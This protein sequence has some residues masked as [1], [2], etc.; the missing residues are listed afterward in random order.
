MM[1]ENKKF[2]SRVMMQRTSTFDTRNVN[3]ENRSFKAVLSSETKVNRFF[4]TELLHHRKDA[5]DLSKAKHGIPLLFNHDPTK[6]IGRVDKIKLDDSG[7]LRGELSFSNNSLANEVYRDVSEDFL[8]GVSIGYR[9]TEHIDTETGIE[10]T[11]WSLHEVSITAIEADI[12]A[13]VNR[14]IDNNHENTNEGLPMPD[15]EKKQVA[16]AAIEAYKA[17]QKTRKDDI[18]HC[19]TEIPGEWGDLQT[20]AIADENFTPDMVRHEMLKIMGKNTESAGG[21]TKYGEDESDKMQRGIE[22][23]LRV[24]V[25]SEK[26]KAIINGIRS[27]E[28]FGFSMMDIARVC[29]ERSGA[30]IRGRSNLQIMGDAFVMSQRAIHGVVDFPNI[31]ANVS[32]ASMQMAY[33]EAAETWRQWCRVGNLSDFKLTDRP[34]LSAFDDL[35]MVPDKDDYTEGSFS[36]LKESIQLAT[37]GRLFKLTRQAMINDSLDG[38]GRIPQSMGRAAARTVGTLAYNVILNNAIMNQ[39]GEAVFSAAHLNDIDSGGSGPTVGL[40]EAGILAMA[41]QQ[42]PSENATLGI[43]PSFMLVPTSYASAGRVL[44]KGEFEPGAEPGNLQPNPVQGL[45]SVISEHRLERDDDKPWFMVA[46]QNNA[47]T[48]EVA[49]LNGAD[50]PALEQDDPFT[51]DGVTYKVRIDAAAQAIDFRGMVRFSDQTPPP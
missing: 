42:D 19:F 32:N 29:L 20:R 38:L 41:L 50:S 22:Q 17:T 26:D 33:E 3:K 24:K 4:G 27:N 5:I 36:D 44:M 15:K 16:D 49:F 11:R 6:P 46:A 9:V 43:D 31:L 1:P 18:N 14:S 25:G 45:L 10:A 37:Y 2:N 21:V 7:K 23:A 8:N 39:D 13:G 30:N 40:V 35:P 34:N 47:E 48:I 28:F 12:I 51:Y